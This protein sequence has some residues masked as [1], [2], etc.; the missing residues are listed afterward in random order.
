MFSRRQV[1]G[2]G[3]AASALGLGSPLH[4]APVFPVARATRV[5]HLLVDARFDDAMEIARQA[6][7]PGL[8]ILPLPRDVL[9][10]WYDQLA[11]MLGQARGQERVPPSFFAGVTTERGLFLLST[12]AQE[13]RLRVRFTARHAAQRGGLITHD[14]AGPAALVSRCRAPSV[15][16]QSAVGT[17]LRS[18][19]EGRP[20]QMRFSSPRGADRRD[21]ALVSWVIGP[22]LSG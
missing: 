21:E 13:H 12:L 2:C 22:A 3:L 14:I 20:I 4:A 8:E 17:A 6:A 7:M 18:C 5:T 11:P 10:L 15:P 19:P 1:I 9:E 16:W